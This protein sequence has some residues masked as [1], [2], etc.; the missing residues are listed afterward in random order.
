LLLMCVLVLQTY[1][2]AASKYKLFYLV[3]WTVSETT[4]LLFKPWSVDLWFRGSIDWTTICREVLGWVPS[5]PHWY[6]A[7]PNSPTAFVHQG[8]VAISIA[9]SRH[10]PAVSWSLR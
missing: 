4:I 9:A 8:P 7:R 5:Q 2:G 3:E 1:S 6:L 10:A